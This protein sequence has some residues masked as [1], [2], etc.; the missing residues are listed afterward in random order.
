MSTILVVSKKSFKLCHSC[1]QFYQGICERHRRLIGYSVE[2]FKSAKIKCNKIKIRGYVHLF[3]YTRTWIIS[4]SVGMWVCVFGDVVFVYIKQWLHL[5]E[6]DDVPFI[7][8]KALAIP[9][10]EIKNSVLDGKPIS[11]IFLVCFFYVYEHVML[12]I[13][14]LCQIPNAFSHVFQSN[15]HLTWAFHQRTKTFGHW[16]NWKLASDSSYIA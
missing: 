4:S 10:L 6:W 12:S 5:G 15:G 3:S 16:V 8:G 2:V 9:P 7:S 1:C 14:L 11:R 13:L